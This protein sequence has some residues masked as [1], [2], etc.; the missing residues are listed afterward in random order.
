MLIKICGITSQEMARTA[1][2]AGA[3]IIG[4]VFARSKRQI[5]PEK[6]ASIAR[7]LPSFVKTAGV[8]VNEDIEKMRA[9][10]EMA[11]LDYIQLHGEEPPSIANKLNRNIIKAFSSEQISSINEENHHYEYCLVDGPAL[12]NRGGNGKTFDWTLTRD[13]PKERFI[14]AGGLTPENVQQ[15]I[16]FVQPAGVDVSSGVE[17][18]GVKDPEKIKQFIENAKGGKRIEKLYNA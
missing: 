1:A 12:E 18:N 11:E 3:D 13:L 14:L 4:F 9:I 16:E 5:T 2:E 7:T 6:A 15:A 17:T 10:S 8:F